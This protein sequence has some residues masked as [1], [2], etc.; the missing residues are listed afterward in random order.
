MAK[1]N[2]ATQ[3]TER[4][5]VAEAAKTAYLKADGDVRE[6]VRIL[7][8]AVRQERDLRDALTDPLISQ[9]CYDAV[10]K[11]CHVQ[12]RRVWAPP[13]EKLVKSKVTGAHRVVQLA[14]GT[15]LM[16]PLP[17]GKRLGEASREEIASAA[18]FYERQAGDM[19]TKGRW[20]RLIAQ[21][22]PGDQTV[23]DVLTDERLRE[24]QEEAR[25]G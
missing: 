24:L 23:G 11:Q 22:V 5:L 2:T 12:R 20:L 14:A 8:T 17:G 18:E 7:E 10:R 19:A 21:S 16:F 3:A 13:A 6:A 1:S 25:N 9:A 15:L 4:D